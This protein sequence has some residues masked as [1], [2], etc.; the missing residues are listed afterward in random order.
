MQEF[1]QYVPSPLLALAFLAAGSVI[2]I[3]V[4]TFL[5]K[6]VGIRAQHIAEGV[7]FEE[8]LTRTF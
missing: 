8:R 6:Y 4:Q 1:T 3:I 7:N 2:T 5:S